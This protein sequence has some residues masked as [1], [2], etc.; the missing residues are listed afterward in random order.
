MRNRLEVAGADGWIGVVV[1]VGG[2]AATP[3]RMV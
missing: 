3:A 1:G 2:H